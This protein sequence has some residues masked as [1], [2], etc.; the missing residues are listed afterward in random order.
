MG[1]EKT[2]HRAA[3]GVYVGL[4]GL[5]AVWLLWLAPPPDAL[6]SAVA[7]VL[8]APL[9]LPIRGVLAGRRYTMAW[10]TMFI[11]LY[12]IH[13]VSAVAGPPPARWLGLIEAFLSLG[14]FV[15]A[16]AYLRCSR[17]RTGTG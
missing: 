8:L 2:L 11:L 3:Q 16:V 10:S 17:I 14:Y 6:M 5:M 15:L 13:G 12:F 7:L 4:F 9:L 1:I